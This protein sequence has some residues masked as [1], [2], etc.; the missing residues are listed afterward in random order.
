MYFDERLPCSRPRYGGKWERQE[1]EG[2]KPGETA[3]RKRKSFIV[4][5]LSP[6]YYKLLGGL[7]KPK[8]DWKRFVADPISTHDTKI[9]INQSQHAVIT[10]V[11]RD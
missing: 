9:V 5:A 11:T 2:K 8:R 7:R 3:E 1:S 6:K 4:F 10:S